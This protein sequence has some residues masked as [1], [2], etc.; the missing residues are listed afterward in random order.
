MAIA[1]KEWLAELISTLDVSE[2]RFFTRYANQTGSGESDKFY[3][4]FRHLSAG[5]EFDDP[6][7][8]ALLGLT[9]PGQLANLQRHLYGRILDSL[10]L[11]HRR[12]EPSVRVREQI[13]HASLLYERGLYLQALRVLAKAKQLAA[14]YHLDLLHL[15]IIDFEKTIE[16]RHI[17]RATSDRMTELTSESRRRQDVMS[18]RVRQSNLQ[19]MLQ[20]HFI[21]H[22]H[23]STPAE[24]RKF[25]QL[26]HHHF[27]DPVL[28][29]ATYMERILGHQCRF[30]YHYNLLQLDEATR[31]AAQW[32]GII[33]AR[34]ELREREVNYYTKG[35][36]R[37]LLLA[38]L[39]DDAEEHRR[40][41][42]ALHR[43]LTESA[44]ARPQ[45]STQQLAEIVLLRAEINQLLLDQAST[46]GPARLHALA[47]RILGTH[48]TD[49]HK[50][51]VL[52]YK[53]AVLACLSERPRLG[54]EY[55]SPVLNEGSPLRYDL[56][57]YARLLQLWM[58]YRLGHHEFVGYG[59]SNLAR[60]LGRI[61]YRSDYPT[62]VVRLLRGLL[63]KGG[64]A[65]A[66]QQFRDHLQPLLAGVFHLREL[67]YLDVRRLL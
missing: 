38:F 28:P 5:G 36:D 1:K 65:A 33:E 41:H 20:R 42:A 62:L 50:L 60:Y 24:A 16:S 56:M 3:R 18:S 34:S 27:S 7:L 67:R 32:T 9:G 21:L 30:W 14:T 37:R 22:G 64:E 55:L 48:G 15:L 54:L 52:Y 59:L 57:V 61:G 43:F 6:Q 44:S 58:H 26:Y 45:R 39:R 19:L 51:L 29:R 63:R 11:Q 10:R 31:H 66:R 25:Y 17:T 53:L 40:V 13:D 35:M 47:D 2:K 8:P 46:C 49:R 4:L 12:R 23:V